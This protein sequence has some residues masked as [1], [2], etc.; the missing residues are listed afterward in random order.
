[1]RDNKWLFIGTDKQIGELAVRSCLKEDLTLH[2]IGTDHYSDELG[3]RIADYSPRQI[4]FP[5]VQMKDLI[6][7]SILDE[8]MELYTG[9]AS[10]EW[11]KPLKGAGLSL[12]SYTHK[13]SNSSGEMRS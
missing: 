6:P 1:M 8:G 5:I 3:K 10:E 7:S 12:H 9:I 11:L 13:K 2:H 4:V